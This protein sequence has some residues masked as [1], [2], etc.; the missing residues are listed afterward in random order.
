MKLAGLSWRMRAG[1]LYVVLSAGYDLLQAVRGW[2][3]IQ[4]GHYRANIA[5]TRILLSGSHDIYNAQAQQDAANVYFHTQLSSLETFVHPPQTAWILLPLARLDPRTGY[6]VFL[7]I[8]IGCLAA[9]AWLLYRHVLPESMDGRG[10]MVVAGTCLFSTTV[11]WSLW[12][13]AWDA[14]LVLPAAAAVVCSGSGRRFAAG[15]LLS[16]LLVKP[17]LIWLLPVLLAGARQWR[18]LAGFAVGALTWVLTV[19]LIV[20]V[21]HWL[22]W[23]KASA[24]VWDAVLAS[25]SVPGAVSYL[26]SSTTVTFWCAVVLGLAAIVMTYIWRG[27]LRRNAEL[28]IGLGIAVSLATSP[29]IFEYG[30]T[31]LAVPLCLW[32]RTQP[33]AAM[34]VAIGLSV[35]HLAVGF[36]LD[37]HWEVFAPVI[38]VIGLARALPTVRGEHRVLASLA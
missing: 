13:G 2:R 37:W 7:A 35:A 18:T 12:W 23:T 28:A 25:V 26:F 16:L 30:L 1:I 4:L 5:A 33:R 20:G 29:Y 6:A 10:R 38:A 8:G 3:G 32:A 21:D 15:L 9:A 14:F 34:A 11:G 31:L 36:G 19:P 24:G 17:N 27:R 22:D